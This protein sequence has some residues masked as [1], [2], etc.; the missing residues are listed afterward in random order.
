MPILTK[1]RMLYPDGSWVETL[2]LSEAEIHGPF[3]TVEEEIIEQQTE[4]N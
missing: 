2:D 3:I 1:Y 4:N